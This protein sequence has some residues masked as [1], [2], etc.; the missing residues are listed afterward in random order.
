MP[1]AAASYVGRRRLSHCLHVII[2]LLVLLLLLLLMLQA[3]STAATATAPSTPTLTSST[4]ETVKT[5]ASSAVAAA[6]GQGMLHADDTSMIQSC[7]SKLSINLPS[8]C[9]GYYNDSSSSAISRSMQSRWRHDDQSVRE[10][11]QAVVSL[12]LLFL[13]HHFCLM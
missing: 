10:K 3:M 8:T 6:P 5:N 1:D 11:G 9:Q 2:I 7:S 12:T 4:G 13:F